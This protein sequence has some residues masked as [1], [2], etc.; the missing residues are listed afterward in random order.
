V[1]IRKTLI[2]RGRNSVFFVLGVFIAPILMAICCNRLLPF[3]ATVDTLPGSLLFRFLQ[4]KEFRR[5]YRN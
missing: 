2:H 1:F 5:L 3:L 4:K